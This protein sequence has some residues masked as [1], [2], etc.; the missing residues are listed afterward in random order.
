MTV[1]VR[2]IKKTR[3][4][5][6]PESFASLATLREKQSSKPED[7]PMTPQIFDSAMTQTQAQV[8]PT[9]LRREPFFLYAR[10]GIT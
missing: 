5:L 3:R 9:T 10:C 8:I 7:K 4:L 2:K 6:I 1:D